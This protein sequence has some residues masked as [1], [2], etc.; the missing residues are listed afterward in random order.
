MAFTAR[1]G[2]KLDV[3]IRD[4]GLKAGKP[5]FTL[6][7]PDGI[8][9]NVLGQKGFHIDE[10]GLATTTHGDNYIRLSASYRIGAQAEPI[11]APDSQTHP[12]GSGIWL[13]GL[14][15]QAQMLSDD[16][17][18]WVALDGAV[19]SLR[20]KNSYEIEG[21]GWM[22]DEVVG[23]MRLSEFG[24]GIRVLL[25]L[26][27]THFILSGL[28][29]K[30]CVETGNDKVDYLLA[31]LTFGPIPFGSFT[32]IKASVL[33]ARN[34]LPLL[35][36]P[37]GVE[38][39][40]RM[41]K[42]YKAQPDGLELPPSRVMG[43]WAPSPDSWALGVAL[44]LGL[45]N[46]GKVKLDGFGLWLKTPETWSLLVGLELR[47]A[48][49]PDPVGWLAVEYD[50]ASGR[51]G[52]TGGISIGVRQLTKSNK[53]SDLAKFTGAVFISNSPRTIA[54]GHIEDVD[55]LA[56]VQGAAGEVRAALPGRLL[57]LQL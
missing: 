4:V 15:V 28:L 53:I 48:D 30:G 57:L 21:G 33:V 31:G 1:D 12:A 41:L 13:R 43:A 32:I 50:E 14:R 18:P 44:R 27:F 36:A 34:Y 39:N 2:R 37:T 56:A 24:F 45:G 46:S 6:W 16:D 25:P 51:W 42:W 5:S 22:R 19:V 40:L 49:I 20:K 55:F 7:V 9:L 26:G 8:D 3:V 52:A 17:H 47:W 29:V 10:I 11:A 23:G 38:Q 35:P 54:L